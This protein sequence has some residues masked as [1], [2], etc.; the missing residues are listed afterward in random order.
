[1]R[2]DIPL[3]TSSETGQRLRL[4]ALTLLG[5]LAGISAFFFGF[6]DTTVWE[7][8]LLAGLVILLAFFVARPMVPT[9]A[10]AIAACGLFGLGFWALASTGWADAND[11]AVTEGARWI[12]Y[13]VFFM[14]LL[15]LLRDE[16][17]RRWL[18][19]A[20]VG[21]ILVMAVYLLF[22][23]LTD[24]QAVSDLFIANRLN[25]PL[26]YINGVATYLLAGFWPMVA[27]AERARNHFVRGAASLAAVQLLVLA[28]LTQSRG[29]VVAILA[30]TL[31][32]IAVVP[33]RVTRGCILLAIAVGVGVTIPALAQ[34]VDLGDGALAVDDLRSVVTM[35]LLGGLITGV[36]VASGSWLASGAYRRSP[37]SAYTLRVISGAG[38]AVV[39]VLALGATI[40]VA[41]IKS[42]QIRDQVDSFT[43]LEETDGGSRLTSGGGNRYDYWRVAVHQFKNDP[44]T[45]IGAGNYR[46][47]YYQERKTSEDVQ[48]AHSIELQAL[49]EL[50]LIGGLA[51]V[52]F[53][54]A[55]GFGFWVTARGG[56]GAKAAD[57]A[58]AIAA[59]GT[60]LVWLFHTSVDWMHLLPGLTA[61][62]I[63][64]AATL[65]PPLRAI[66]G[67]RSLPAIV[68]VA[69]L[70]ALVSVPVL[71]QLRSLQLQ[72]QAIEKLESDP[73]EAL[74]AARDS[75]RLE[76]SQRSYYF[77]AAALARLG[78]YEPARDSLLAAAENNPKD[79]VAWSLLG[80]LATRRGLD[81]AADLYYRRALR[82]NPRD[83]G[84]IRLAQD[85]SASP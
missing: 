65:L 85:G 70:V 72:N 44:L 24:D 81:Q 68:V 57:P 41:G 33:G 1:M 31:L 40:V 55:V 61:V 45:G 5:F 59:G 23:L 4:I 9:G 7:P 71:K 46:Q 34:V 17:S 79:F 76:P 30:S 56:R 37:D 50:G 21:G 20:T 8:M 73:R 82:L 63:C 42:D 19:G 15:Y 27:V 67:R 60:F 13:G 26:D 38:L 36:A 32:V 47:T 25:S 48:Q 69:A 28:V 3:G 78:L 64:S 43:E 2:E 35:G 39:C 53:V 12:L 22:R 62:A 29:A 14:V 74:A 16:L 49:G 10:A 83:P 52:A 84:L 80:D 77:Q 11:L 6:Y 58:L 54:G 75:I 18:V 51:L 66:P